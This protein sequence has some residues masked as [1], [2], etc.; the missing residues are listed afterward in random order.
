[1][2]EKATTAPSDSGKDPSTMNMKQW[3][4]GQG[5]LNEVQWQLPSNRVCDKKAPTGTDRA[6]CQAR[7]P[8][9]GDRERLAMRQGDML[10]PVLE[11]V[12]NPRIREDQAMQD[13]Q[14]NSEKIHRATYEDA[15]TRAWFDYCRSVFSTV[16]EKGRPKR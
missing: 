4:Q 6:S 16:R 2:P 1:M 3:Y 14:C 5:R 11:R 13:I 7:E 15:N 9:E 12:A 8:I 10:P